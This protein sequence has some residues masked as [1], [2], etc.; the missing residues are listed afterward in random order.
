[1]EYPPQVPPTSAK[2]HRV[3]HRQWTLP[4]EGNGPL[5]LLDSMK[6]PGRLMQIVI[7]DIRAAADAKHAAGEG[8]VSI[9]LLKHF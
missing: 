5:L 4:V 2:A 1:M 8:F 6:N 3:R 9:G 7:A